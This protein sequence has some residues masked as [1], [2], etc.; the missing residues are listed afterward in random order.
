[1][2]Y[3]K[4]NWKKYRVLVIAVLLIIMSTGT[5][6]ADGDLFSATS[7]FVHDVSKW[8]LGLGS[9]ACG[10]S[11]ATGALMRWGNLGDEQQIHQG[12]KIMIM[13][14]KTYAVVVGLSLI[15]ALISRYA[16]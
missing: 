5:C 9:A 7:R 2:K 11:V 16:S 6:F 15:L 3:I 14:F 8:L 12:K 1:M 13:S 4:K 10:I